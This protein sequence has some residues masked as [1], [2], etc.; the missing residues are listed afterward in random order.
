MKTYTLWISLLVGLISPLSIFADSHRTVYGLASTS[1]GVGR[2][3]RFQSNNPTDVTFLTI[4]GISSPTEIVGIDFR[5]TTNVLFALALTGTSLQLYSVDTTTGI[6]TAVGSALTVTGTTFGMDFNP[7]V[8][9]IRVVSNTEENFRINPDTGALAGSD[10][11]LDYVAGDANDV[12]NPN[13]LGAAYTNNVSSATVTTLLGIDSIL[14][15]LTRIGGP[16]GSTSPNTG[17]LNSLGSTGLTIPLTN[18][19]FDIANGKSPGT[20]LAL[21]AATASGETDSK[22][23]SVD[24]AGGRATL[25]GSFPSTITVTD[26][27]ISSSD[28][29]DP[30]VLVQAITYKKVKSVLKNGLPIVINCSEACDVSISYTLSASLSQQLGLANSG[31]AVIATGSV[32]LSDAGQDQTTLTLTQEA[33]DAI[34]SST[35]QSIKNYTTTVTAT[36]TDLNGNTGTNSLVVKLFRP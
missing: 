27:A 29:V 35:G 36:A 16:N 11:A 7:A 20:T 2:L 4:V 28:S 33:I 32:S 6:P 18:I 31:Q 5:P 26:L 22:L 34:K 23:Y 21:L 14:G 8:D 30:E 12:G 9:R 10:T 1:S 19:G 24:I 17:E 25:V 13:I 3:A 15:I